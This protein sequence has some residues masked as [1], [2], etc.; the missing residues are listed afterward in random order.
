MIEI[1][2]MSIEN[3]DD[4][5]FFARLYQNNEKL[6]FAVAN[7]ILHAQTKA[8]EAIQETFVKAIEHLD[9][10]KG[11]DEEEIKAWLIV[12]AKNIS[13]NL[14]KKEAQIQYFDPQDETESMVER[15]T[16]DLTDEINYGRLKEL[17]RELPDTYKNILYLRFV[18]EWSYSEIAHELGVSVNLVGTRV[19]RGREILIRKLKNEESGWEKSDVRK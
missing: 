16:A 7:G 11:K 3:D 6:L 5:A 18:C 19:L 13:I 8:E 10:L 15:Y 1:L 14:V 9:K 4:R 2:M 12:V 17:I